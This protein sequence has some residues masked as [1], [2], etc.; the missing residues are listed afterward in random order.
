MEVRLPRWNILPQI[1]PEKKKLIYGGRAIDTSTV[2]KEDTE[3][4]PLAKGMLPLCWYGRS[5]EWWSEMYDN[6]AIR[7][8]I[9]LFPGSGEAAL[10][11]LQAKPA[12]PYL[13]ICLNEAHK[14]WAEQHVDQYIIK[15][16]QQE[17]SPFY[18]ATMKDIL[19]THFPPP[20]DVDE[21][22]AED[23]EEEPEEGDNK[24]DDD[25]ADWK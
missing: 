10:A 2:D 23:G 6:F 13:G 5:S 12:I 15:Q 11:A 14:A 1:T 22:D 25:D 19:N 21:D 4:P 18:V 3:C 7:A 24:D 16:M 20:V 8:V 9:D 17:G